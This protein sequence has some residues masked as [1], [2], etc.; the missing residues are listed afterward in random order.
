MSSS[1]RV[2]NV[3]DVLAVGEEVQV[4]IIKIEKGKLGLS[5]KDVDQQTG[6]DL[7]PSNSAA[8]TKSGGSGPLSNDTPPLYSIHHGKVVKLSDF[9]CFVALDGYRKHGLVHLSHLASYKVDSV[10]KAVSMGDSVWVKVIKVEEGGKIGLSMKYVQQATGKDLDPQHVNTVADEARAQ[11]SSRFDQAT[12]ADAPIELGAVHNVD[13]TRCGA[14]GHLAVDCMAPEGMKFDAAR[15]AE[16]EE[17]QEAKREA[18]EKEALAA[19]AQKNASLE[20]IKEALR[21]IQEAK[22]RKRAKKEKKREKKSKKESRK[23]SKKKHSSSK[24][25]KKRSSRSHR[26][27]S[28]SRSRS[29]SDSS[30]SSSDDSRSPSPRR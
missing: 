5:L 11:K 15:E 28:R 8:T 13:C 18:Q 22:E 17:E 19:A 16:E 20:K 26:G 21:I 3:E 9:G 29:L 23:K 30:A 12:G 24:D 6:E 14:R 1:R 7:D 27:R 25:S 10:D 4:K 2:D